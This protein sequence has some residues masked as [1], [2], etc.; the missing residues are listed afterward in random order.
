MEKEGTGSRSWLFSL[1]CWD[2]LLEF[3]E[4]SLHVCDHWSGPG[5]RLPLYFLQMMACDPTTDGTF[6]IA[7]NSQLFQDF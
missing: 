2:N 4:P 3:H 5:I 1:V 7:D 6:L